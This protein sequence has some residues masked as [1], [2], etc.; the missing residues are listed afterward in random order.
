MTRKQNVC[1]NV[2]LL[3]HLMLVYLSETCRYQSYPFLVFSTTY[4]YQE[5][6]RHEE[7]INQV[8]IYRIAC[9]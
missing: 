7:Q 5:T 2:A 3:L 9:N 1:T 8:Y 4:I 6:S